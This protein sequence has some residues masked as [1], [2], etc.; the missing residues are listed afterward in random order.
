M[1]PIHRSSSSTPPSCVTMMHHHPTRQVASRHPGSPHC[2]SMREGAQGCAS[3]PHARANGIHTAIPRPCALETRWPLQACRACR[4]GPSPFDGRGG[5]PAAGVHAT[6]STRRRV[7]LSSGCELAA[8][9]RPRCER[10]SSPLCLGGAVGCHAERCRLMPARSGSQC[11]AQST[12]S[13]LHV[14]GARTR[15]AVSG[16]RGEWRSR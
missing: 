14:P 10:A 13:S 3:A 1:R 2:E 15:E 16:G 5:A 6:V 12:R 8:E 9:A 4:G 7:R 11:S